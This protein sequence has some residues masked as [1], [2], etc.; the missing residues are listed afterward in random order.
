[1]SCCVLA[2]ENITTVKVQLCVISMMSALKL[3]SEVFHCDYIH[4]G[5][6][7]EKSKDNNE[8]LYLSYRQHYKQILTI[9]FAHTE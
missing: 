5:T 9:M 7:T 8:L 3:P 6:R 4:A 1:M 2:R